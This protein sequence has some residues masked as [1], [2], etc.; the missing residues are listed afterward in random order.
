MVNDPSFYCENCGR[1]VSSAMDICPGCGQE[2]S[3]VRCPSCG[4]TGEDTLFKVKCPKCGYSGVLNNNIHLGLELYDEKSKE[5]GKQL[6]VWL[7]R[8]LI[9]IMV[10]VIIG[11]FRVYFLL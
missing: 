9:G 6:P 10:I 2:F 1:K 3:K 8:V 7:Y 11:L 4:F 5:K